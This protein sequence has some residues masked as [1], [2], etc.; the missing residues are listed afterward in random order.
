MVLVKVR[1]I[2]ILATLSNGSKNRGKITFNNV[3]IT[4]VLFT[5]TLL[6]VG[7]CDEDPS[8]N[9]QVDHGEF[10]IPLLASRF[11]TLDELKGVVSINYQS[12]LGDTSGCVE[13]IYNSN[14]QEVRSTLHAGLS[15]KDVKEAKD[16]GFGDKL[17]VVLGAPAAVANRLELSSVYMLARRRSDL[18]GEGDVAFIDIAMYSVASIWTREFAYQYA[19]DS[20]EKGYLNTFNHITAQSFI[21]TLYTR[22]LAD[23]V[24]DLHELDNMPELV[25]GNF[26]EEQLTNPNNNP[27]DNYVDIINNEIGQFIGLHLKVK[28]GIASRSKW[29]TKL[30]CDYLNDLQSYYSRSLKIGMKPFTEESEVVQKFTVKLND[31]IEGIPLNSH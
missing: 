17:G 19:G 25:S 30:L 31:A 24:A 8:A 28:Y 29:S 14:E 11:S 27:V 3:G 20:S 5:L 16:G 12:G 2:V 21:T 10:P 4:A 18:Y 1:N 22:E 13:L 23:L 9:A 26:T 7:G 6:T 15:Q